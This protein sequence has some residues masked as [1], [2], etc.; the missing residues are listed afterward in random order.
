M[1]TELE[2]SVF[3]FSVGKAEFYLR[4]DN[5]ALL[6]IEKQGFDFFETA[7]QGFT[8]KSAKCFLECGLRCWAESGG[9]NHHAENLKAVADKT[10]AALPADKL[11]EMLMQAVLSALPKP[12]LGAKADKKEKGDFTGIFYYFCDIMGKPEKLFWELTLREVFERWDSY[13][14]FHGYKKAPIEVKRYDD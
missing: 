3:P 5:R 6:E 2:R 8:A 10:A 1:F 12:V 14:I 7:A 9:L 13:A 11:S 4:F